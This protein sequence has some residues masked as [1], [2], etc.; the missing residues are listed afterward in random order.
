MTATPTSTNTAAWDFPSEL[1]RRPVLD[2][3][4][5]VLSVDVVVGSKRADDRVAPATD[6]A[7]RSDEG[8]G[9]VT[10]VAEPDATGGVVIHG[11]TSAFGAAVGGVVL[12]AKT[13]LLTTV[14]VV[15]E[16]APAWT[17]LGH[18]RTMQTDAAT[19]TMAS[20]ARRVSRR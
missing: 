14:A 11:A 1:A 15:V 10:W 12:C 19:T 20:S 13:V 2:D 5:V 9:S 3:G 16:G 8:P 17:G 6:V 4:G 7:D 18:A